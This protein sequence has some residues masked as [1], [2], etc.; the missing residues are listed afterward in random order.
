MTGHINDPRHWH[1][2][3]EELRAVVDDFKDKK[4]KEQL[5]RCAEDY[6]RMGE[7]AAQRADGKVA[8]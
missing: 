6:D 3:A 4:C 1:D 2:R 7:R 8:S 5:L